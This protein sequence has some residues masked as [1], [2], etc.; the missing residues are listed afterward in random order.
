MGCG[1]GSVLM[2]VAYKTTDLIS[3]GIEVQEIS[4]DSARRSIQFNNL[5][6]RCQV[7][8]GDIRDKLILDQICNKFDK[9]DLITGT[10]P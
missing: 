7:L 8:D 9:L 10:P 2:M 4:S 5:K 3:I 6:H 1:I